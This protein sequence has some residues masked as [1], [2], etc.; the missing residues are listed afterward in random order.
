MEGFFSG[1]CE[2]ETLDIPSVECLK[3]ST[4]FC[5]PTVGF[6][7]AFLKE[8]FSEEI[9]YFWVIYVPNFVPEILY[10]RTPGQ[11]GAHSISIPGFGL[12]SIISLNPALHNIFLK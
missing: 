3:R 11:Q 4:Y 7:L 12:S 5:Q 10:T 8:L 1:E 2:K 6:C 9:T